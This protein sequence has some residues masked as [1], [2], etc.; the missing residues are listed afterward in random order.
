[1]NDNLAHLESQYHQISEL[2]NL[3]EELV[4]T[5][6]HPSI[7]NPDAQLDLIEPLVNQIG[8]STDML[9]EEFIEIAGKQQKST[10]RRSRVEGALRKIYSALDV[11]QQQVKATTNVA[12]AIVEK[13]KRQVESVIVLF[14]EYVDLTL[15]RIMHKT[16]IEELKK[17]QEK[18]AQMLYVA[19]RN[20]TRDMGA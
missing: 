6:E 16:Q 2:Y 19:D 20:R 17:R 4:A 9:C 15:D 3:A 13:I 8:D 7:T 12:N 5:A 1:M 14:V 11:Y 10:T 18:I